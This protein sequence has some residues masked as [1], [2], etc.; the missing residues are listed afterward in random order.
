MTSGGEPVPVTGPRQ[1]GWAAPLSTSAASGSTTCSI[2]SIAM[3]PPSFAPSHAD[4]PPNDACGAPGTERFGPDR[5]V[6][7]R[8]RASDGQQQLAKA[9]QHPELVRQLL[10]VHCPLIP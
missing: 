5:S 2:P 7:L 1:P 6:A 8:V 4:A 3:A 10:L 9:V